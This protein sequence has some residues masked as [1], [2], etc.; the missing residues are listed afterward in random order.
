ML[1]STSPW[2]GPKNTLR[3]ST[4]EAPGNGN[5]R[6]NSFRHTRVTRPNSR[7]WIRLKANVGASNIVAIRLRVDG[8]VVPEDATA[9]AVTMRLHAIGYNAS[10]DYIAR[11]DLLEEI[12]LLRDD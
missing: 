6:D 3:I 5:D 1:I 10:D 9:V 8:P 11:I 7:F 12:M 4:S 2:V